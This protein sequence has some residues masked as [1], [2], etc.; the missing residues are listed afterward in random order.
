[1][2]I[3]SYTNLCV[4]FLALV[5]TNS[6]CALFQNQQWITVGSVK[7]SSGSILISDPSYL[8]EIQDDLSITFD[9]PPG[10]YEVSV[11]QAD[12]G[13]WGQR[14]VQARV[15]FTSQAFVNKRKL[16]SVGIDSATLAVV[17]PL[18]LQSEW[19]EVGSHRDGVIIGVDQNQISDLLEQNG[20]RIGERTEW[21]N[22][23][24]DPVSQDDEAKFGALIESNGLHGMVL[25]STGNSYDQLIDK[26]TTNEAWAD[27]SFADGRQG[28]V[29]AFSTGLGDGE[30]PVYGLYNG[31]TL[32]GVEIDFD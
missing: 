7:I 30:Y 22:T 28:F 6:G 18:Q 23:L 16:G 5:F 14:I 26:M 12:M 29:V 4:V 11:L 25:V 31:P 15:I 24:I 19:I 20:Y 27:L 1:M 13:E 10:I 3:N 21:G 8:P 17:D 9:V 2:K 32:V